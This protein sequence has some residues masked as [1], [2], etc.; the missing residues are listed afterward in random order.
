MT[1]EDALHQASDDYLRDAHSLS[2]L[3]VITLA[4]QAGYVALLSAV[5]EEV[6]ARV[7]DH[8]DPAAA[9]DGATR[10]GLSVADVRFAEQVA[11]DYCVPDIAQ[12]IRPEDCLVWANRVRAKLGW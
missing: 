2:A 7:V 12:R 6:V 10:L 8:P 4:F 1:R 5:P 9:A 11:T 3:C